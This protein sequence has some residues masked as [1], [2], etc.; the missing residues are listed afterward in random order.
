MSTR[1]WRTFKVSVL[2]PERVL[3]YASTAS[4]LGAFGLAAYWIMTGWWWAYFTATTTLLTLGGF[5]TIVVYVT[6]LIDAA[7]AAL[8]A[9]R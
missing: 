3:V 4:A 6:R 7:L 8:K 1:D 5:L 2:R 9:R